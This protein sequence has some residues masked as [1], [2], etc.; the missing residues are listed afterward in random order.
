[1]TST[2]LT[3]AGA[4]RRAPSF[5][6]FATLKLASYFAP[7]GQIGMQLPLPQHAGRPSCWTLLRACG[8]ELTCRPSVFA[9]AAYCLPRYD[10]GMGGI[11]YAVERG[12][13]S[14]G[15]S[16]PETPISRSA[17]PYHGSRSS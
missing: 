1:V 5:C 7:I 10:C 4:T 12:A 2:S 11:G 14:E 6:A 16:A 15:S 13:P 9:A 3:T 8:V 17:L